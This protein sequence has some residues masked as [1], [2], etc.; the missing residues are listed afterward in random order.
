MATRDSPNKVAQAGRSHRLYLI[1]GVLYANRYLRCPRLSGAASMRGVV[2]IVHSALRKRC[3]P[4]RL[5]LRVPDLPII[6]ARPRRR[7]SLPLALLSSAL[8]IPWWAPASA[9]EI[10][11]MGPTTPIAAPDQ[12]G[13]NSHVPIGTVRQPTVAD[14]GW[15]AGITLG[16]LYTDNLQL[17]ASGRPKQSPMVVPIFRDWSTTNSPDIC[18]R[19]NRVTTS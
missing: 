3:Q 18:T 19:A 2:A 9:Q 8:L 4:C 5:V 6:D 12:Q 16:E 1:V 17:A 13:G 11:P 10:P 14:P 15:V 7:L